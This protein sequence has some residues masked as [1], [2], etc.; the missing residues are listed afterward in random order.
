MH[1]LHAHVPFPTSLGVSAG[2]INAQF[3][4]SLD[5]LLWKPNLVGSI[6]A[7]INLLSVKILPRVD[8]NSYMEQRGFLTTACAEAQ[9]LPD[10][11]YL[12]AQLRQFR[13]GYLQLHPQGPQLLEE[14]AWV[15][16]QLV[17]TI[18]ATPTKQAI[19]A[20]LSAHRAAAECP[21]SGAG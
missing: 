13:A 5:L 20:A 11:C 3:K 14:Y 8:A 10:D 2:E 18:E 19:Y 17:A 21:L 4:K 15:A 1:G 16:P 7:G 9:Q 6:P 12:L